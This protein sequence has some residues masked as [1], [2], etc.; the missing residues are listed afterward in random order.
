M[1]CRGVGVVIQRQDEL[2]G[3]AG[4]VL[5]AEP[6]HLRV[7]L[8]TTA[9]QVVHGPSIGSHPRV[10]QRPAMAESGKRSH[11]RVRPSLWSLQHIFVSNRGL[12]AMRTPDFPGDPRTSRTKL[13]PVTALL[14]TP[15]ECC[16]SLR[17]NAPRHC[18]RAGTVDNSQGR[19]PFMCNATMRSKRPERPR[20][21][22]ASRSRQP[23][24]SPAPSQS[25]AGDSVT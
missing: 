14:P 13:S 2:A 9:W 24:A 22:F 18:G 17:M 23:S 19:P 3:G 6:N 21:G 20:L 10:R 15:W 12:S 7:A 4:G 8:P 25:S 11:G 1:T 16:A 5:V